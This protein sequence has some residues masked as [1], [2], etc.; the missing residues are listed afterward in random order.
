MTVMT[1]DEL[2]RYAAAVIDTCLHIKKGDTVAVHG[3]PGSRPYMQALVEAA[4]AS[5][6]RFVD[7]LYVD[8]VIR[9]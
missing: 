9:R 4:Y 5:G 7:V 8:P 1:P 6:A 2:D 3:E